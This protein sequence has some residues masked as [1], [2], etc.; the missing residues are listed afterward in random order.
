MSK[1]PTMK[2]RLWD[3]K[4]YH[5]PYPLWELI[6]ISPI[7]VKNLCQ[8]DR[9]ERFTGVIAEHGG[10]EIYDGDVVHRQSYT[11]VNGKRR[12]ANGGRVWVVRWTQ[13]KFSNGWNIASGKNAKV[14]GN[15]HQNPELL[16]KL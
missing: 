14:I 8:L 2:F 9:V 6:T 13:S 4:A 3:G 10:T 15:I 16:K 1:Q 5:G 12:V 11:K 7:E